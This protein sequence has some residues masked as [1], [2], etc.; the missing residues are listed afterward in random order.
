VVFEGVAVGGNPG[1]RDLAG[2]AEVLT[3]GLEGFDERSDVEEAADLEHLVNGWAAG[4]DDHFAG[5]ILEFLADEEKGVDAG[6]AEV[7]KGGE[8]ENEMP[9]ASGNQTEDEG[10]ELGGILAVEPARGFDG[11]GVNQGGQKVERWRYFLMTRM[12]FGSWRS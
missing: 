10:T 4:E 3:G 2:S 8:V 12:F 11:D 6:A 9:A 5:G 1:W 7:L